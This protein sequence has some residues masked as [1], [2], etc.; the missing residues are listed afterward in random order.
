MITHFFRFV[1]FAPILVI[2][3]RNSEM[4]NFK[5]QQDPWCWAEQKVFLKDA[6]EEAK[7][8]KHER[9]MKFRPSWSCQVC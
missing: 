1:Y 3:V 6:K 2:C 9:S 5:I 8:V 7:T 4:D